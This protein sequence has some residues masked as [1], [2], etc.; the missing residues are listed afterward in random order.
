MKKRFKIFIVSALTIVFACSVTMAVSLSVDELKQLVLEPS[1]G[2]F[3]GGDVYSDVNVYSQMTSVPQTIVAT[4]TLR[5]SDANVQLLGTSAA[6]TTVTLP[7]VTAKR[8]MSFRF[9]VSGA[10]TGASVTIDS[11]EGDNI[12]GTLIVAGAV[13]D[14]AAED[15][16]NIVTDGENIGDYVE[17]YSDGSQWLIVDSGVL[18]SAKMTCSDPS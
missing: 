13:V 1:L 14:C 10:L 3:P 5:A 7:A 2:A 12:E 11:A 17:L 8:G 18:T 15:Q 9:Q 6:Q 4:T 16:I